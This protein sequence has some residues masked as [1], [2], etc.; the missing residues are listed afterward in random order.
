MRL[1]RLVT[2]WASALMLGFALHAAPAPGQWDQPAGA[3]AEQIAGIL[4]PAQ[5]TLTLRNLSSIAPSDVNA[6]RQLIEQGLKARGVSL[7]AGESANTIRVTLS[8]N[9][10]ARLWVA[11]VAQGNETR[12]VMVETAGDHPGQSPEESH[13]VLRRE[14][15]LGAS[16]LGDAQASNVPDPILG[17]ILTPQGLVVV[18]PHQA[19]ILQ[20]TPGAWRV[21]K[22]IDLNHAPES[23]DPRALLVASPDGNAFTAF[24]PGSECAGT[25]ASAS[26]AAAPG[27]DGWTVRCRASDEPWPIL[28]SS[29]PANPATLKAFYNSA[30]NYFTGVVTPGIGVDLPPF[31]SALLVPRPSGAAMLIGGIDGKEQ[32]V[33]NGTLRPVSGTRDWGS[34]FAVLKSGCGSGVQVIV[35][36]S[37]EAESD[38]LRAYEVTGQEA[39]AASAP[40]TMNGSLTALWTAPDGKSV[41][42]VVRLT[43]GDYEVDRVTALCN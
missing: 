4:G 23:R 31:Y 33:D 27:A 26:N 3:L 13:M 39:I 28:Q 21:Q 40:L 20:G 16:D 6:I 12:I 2:G 9:N 22:K 43:S 7:A 32:L 10:R 15:Y 1:F 29:D 17:A 14:R 18:R 30:R 34:D 11:E 37:G 19:V 41:M 5:A 36:G 38:S 24:L 8:Q 35:S 25:Y 42:A